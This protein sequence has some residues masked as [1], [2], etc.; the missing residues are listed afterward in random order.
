M[1]VFFRKPLWLAALL[2]LGLAASAGVTFAQDSVENRLRRLEIELDTLNR[3]VY[4]GEKPPPSAVSSESATTQAAT[5]VRI[6]QME[7]ELRSLTGQLEQQSYQI[8]QLQ[9]QLERVTSDLEL[10]MQDVERNRGSATAPGSG[11]MQYTTR[12][13]PQPA[14]STVQ[15]SSGNATRRLGTISQ[16]QAGG[17]PS[18]PSANAPASVDMAAAAY[19]NAFAMLK[20]SNFEAAEKEF[21]KFLNQYPDHVLAPNARYW[22]GET[23][24]VRGD[25]ERAARIFAEGYQADPQGAKAQDNLLKMGMS[26]AGLGNKDDA[27]IALRQLEK[28]SASSSSPVMRRAK[29]EMGRLGC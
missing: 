9:Q 3:A 26:L 28:E 2:F 29:Q 10:R 18:T 25:Y 17:I 22:Y 14:P 6:Q 5:E 21:D 12:P 20:S 4:R 24:Y 19:E 27:C 15:P 13:K 7:M 11:G 1:P 16:G 23:F 8:R